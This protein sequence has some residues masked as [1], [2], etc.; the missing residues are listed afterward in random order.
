M[1]FGSSAKLHVPPIFSN[2]ISDNGLLGKEI[3]LIIK[4]K[5]LLGQRQTLATASVA[6]PVIVMTL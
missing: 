4:C 2:T 6:F 1:E 3:H 5:E